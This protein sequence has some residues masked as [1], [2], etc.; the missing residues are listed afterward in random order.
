MC[1]LRRTSLYHC[2]AGGKY[3]SQYFRGITS[4]FNQLTSLLDIV[5]LNNSLFSAINCTPS[6]AAAVALGELPSTVVCAINRALSFVVA[7]ALSEPP[8]SVA[9]VLA[10]VIPLSN[11]FRGVEVSAMKEEEKVS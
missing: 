4:L 6:F 2:S 7:V 10:E 3:S 8:S 5:L 11:S 1:R 9:C